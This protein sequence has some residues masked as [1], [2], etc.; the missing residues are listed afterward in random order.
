MCSRGRKNI[1]YLRFSFDN[2]YY[3]PSFIFSWSL[4]TKPRKCIKVCASFLCAFR[5]PYKFV[6]ARAIEYQVNNHS[7]D[8]FPTRNVDYSIR[9]IFCIVIEFVWNFF[10]T[11]NRSKLPTTCG[12]YCSSLEL[13]F[14]SKRNYFR[15]KIM[16]KRTI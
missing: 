13:F 2:R 8:H 16:T 4:N 14:A 6:Q 5:M 1:W 9:V 3:F 15:H 7:L 10:I 12:S 11:L